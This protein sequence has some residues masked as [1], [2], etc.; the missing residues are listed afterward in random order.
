MTIIKIK[1]YLNGVTGIIATAFVRGRFTVY[2]HIYQV[3]EFGGTVLLESLGTWDGEFAAK[4]ALYAW[5]QKVVSVWQE[6]IAEI[7][8]IGDS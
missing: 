2:V 6:R 8:A 1:H 7:L 5:E 3:D 4:E